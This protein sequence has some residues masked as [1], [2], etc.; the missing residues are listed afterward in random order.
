MIDLKDCIEIG[1]LSKTHGI[2]GELI[3]RLNDLSTDDILE[4]ELVF[5]IIDGLPV[6]FFIEEFSERNHDTILLKLEEIDSETEAKKIV[7]K[8]LFIS[9]KYISGKTIQSL[10][11]TK[12]YI[13][14]AVI[15]IK[16]GQLGI[17]NNIIHNPQNP[18]IYITKGIREIYL[19][20]QEK[21]IEEINEPEKKIIVCCPEGLL[22]LY[23]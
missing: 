8:K 21:F 7:D 3:A 18:L 12:K 23:C 20:L 16:A 13:G 14:Y 19:P 22:S 15:D 2:R 11:L 4:M 1:Y 17:L 5:V 10:Q 6:P 9:N